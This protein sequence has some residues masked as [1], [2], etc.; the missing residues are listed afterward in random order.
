M[1]GSTDLY[2]ILGVERTATS[3]EIKKAYRKLAREHHP[4]VNGHSEAEDRFKE[5][6]AA[7][8]ILSD[9]AKR[10]Q[11]DTFGTTRGPG[12]AAGSPFGD[13]DDIF[14]FF[15]SGASPFGGGARR[16][17]GG[18]GP[19]RASRRQPGEDLVTRAQLSFEESV[20][21]VTSDLELDAM[22]TCETCEGSGCAPGTSP[23]AC[24]TC[25]GAGELQ[26]TQQSIFGTVMTMRA[27]GT[28]RG[29]GEQIASPCASCSG[30]GRTMRRRTV[31][32]EVPGGV[33]EG[34]ELRVGGAGHA[35]RAG[36][37]PGDLY[38]SLSVAPHAVFE[39]H[40]NDLVATLEVPM[41]QAALGTELDVA[42][43][44]GPERIKLE[45][46]TPSGHVVRLKGLGVPHVERRGRGDL[47]LHVQVVTPEGK[48]R[49]ERALLEQLAELR[50]EPSGGQG[51]LRKPGEGDL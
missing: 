16:R 15:F 29:T 48:S 35:G 43:L 13:L 42:T 4:D 26:Q 46:G 24:G 27:C 20:F 14:D 47:Y 33:A 28:C 30:E 45:R 25:G 17:G 9:P 5:I 23:T 51:R 3:E 6:S 1:A 40:G 39:R 36:G 49:K 41:T 32:V 34:M 18:R 11:Y 38:V 22:E 10:Q 8:E 44:D 7:Y 31:T 50:E 12:G 2:A 37:P 21:G 19:R